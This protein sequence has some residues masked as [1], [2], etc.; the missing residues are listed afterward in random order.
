MASCLSI[1]G[2]AYITAWILMHLL[3]PK[4]KKIVL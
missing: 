4:F 1:C 3:V 2:S